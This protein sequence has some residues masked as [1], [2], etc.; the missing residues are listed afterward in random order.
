MIYYVVNKSDKENGMSMMFD[1]LIKQ[2][3]SVCR[4]LL[5]F[6]DKGYDGKSVFIGQAFTYSK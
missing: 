6:V 1:L 3:C 5:Y 4:E 2:S